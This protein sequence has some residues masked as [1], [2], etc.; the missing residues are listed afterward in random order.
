MTAGRP[1]LLSQ[2]SNL[3]TQLKEVSLEFYGLLLLSVSLLYVFSGD[4][5]LISIFS[6]DKYN[7][8]SSK[9]VACQN[10]AVVG[11]DVITAGEVPRF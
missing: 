11:F 5:V 4:N 7:E 6:V 8:I 9:M 2:F 10:R 3:S 1:S